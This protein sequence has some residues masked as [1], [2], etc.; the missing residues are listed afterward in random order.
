MSEI[1]CPKCGE[2]FKVDES[3]Y[4][5]ILNQVRDKEFNR[6]I[7]EHK[8]MAENE[9]QARIAS[10]ELQTEKKYSDIINEK[11]SEITKLKNEIEKM[12]IEHEN[13]LEKE[14]NRLK[15][16]TA[17]IRAENQINVSNLKSRIETINSDH[18][19]EMLEMENENKN[20]IS[21]IEKENHELIS[22]Y[23]RQITERETQI[24]FYK[25]LKLKQSTKMIGE[26]LEKHCENQ[27]NKLRPTAFQN[28]YFEKD[29]DIKQGSKGDYIFRDY[30][31]DGTEF[32]SIMFEMKNEMD[33]T[34]T[35]HKN[36]DFFK[37]L[38]KDRNQKNCEYAVLVSLLE[39]DNE[40]YNDGI[41][42]VSYKYPKMY[43]IRPQYFI[44]M[45]TLLRN[46]ALNSLKYREEIEALK[47]QN[48]DI[49]KFEDN[50]NEFKDRFSR[51]FQIAT[52]KFNTAIDEIDKTISHLQKTKEALLSTGNN[53][54]LA[55]DKAQDL[56]IKRLTK[57][58]PTMAQKF[59]DLKKL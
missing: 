41:V 23:K 14:K 33:T 57:N 4:T 51:N 27:F 43:V 48:I 58:N 30:S 15:E 37:E 5:L 7:E 54:R 17:K 16:E 24:E 19:I 11:D 34:A 38:D 44:P 55:N 10:A 50:M 3:A 40:Y 25:D 26:T 22:E 49:T 12:Q 13:D 28:S 45:I 59:E 9:Q 56:T 6:Q 46:A 47:N 21:E 35:K 42:D 8:R 52:N 36:A 39:S 29:N 31:S 2:V 18:K 1:K 32:I 53:L 20:R